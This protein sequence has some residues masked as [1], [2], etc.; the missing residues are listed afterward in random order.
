MDGARVI[1]G[2]TDADREIGRVAVG[3]TADTVATAIIIVGGVAY[4]VAAGLAPGLIGTLPLAISAAG[5]VVIGVLLLWSV[6]RGSRLLAGLLA[7]VEIGVM[8]GSWVG[9]IRWAVP[10]DSGVAAASMAGMAFIVAVALV[11]KTIQLS[12]LSCPTSRG[13]AAESVIAG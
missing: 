13:R 8:V 6:Y 5:M 12:A 10:Y 9:A 4:L 1:D 7:L 11:F 2:M 3:L